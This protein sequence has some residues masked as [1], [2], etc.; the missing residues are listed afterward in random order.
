MSLACSVHSLTVLGKF[1][2]WEGARERN[3]EEEVQQHLLLMSLI[4]L[5]FNARLVYPLEISFEIEENDLMMSW[6]IKAAIDSTRNCGNDDTK[7]EWRRPRFVSPLSTQ[8]GILLTGFKFWSDRP[9]TSFRNSRRTGTG[10]LLDKKF[11]ITGCYNSS[12]NSSWMSTRSTY[13]SK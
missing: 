11:E 8:L 13:F 7:A 6:A 3:G 9:T 10:A 2:L 12:S 5:A 1:F 4:S